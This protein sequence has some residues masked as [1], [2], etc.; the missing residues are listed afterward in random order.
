MRRI[1]LAL[2]F[3]APALA[4]D[5]PTGAT[6][7]SKPVVLQMANR[8]AP[9]LATDAD[10]FGRLVKA[11]AERDDAA[12]RGMKAGGGFVEVPTGTAA[13]TSAR[14]PAGRLLK[15]SGGPRD[16][17][18]G[19]A[20]E[21]FIREIKPLIREARTEPPRGARTAARVAAPAT[22]RAETSFRSSAREAPAGFYTASD[23][24]AS[25]AGPGHY[26]GAPTKKGGSCRRWVV[27]G[28]NCYQHGG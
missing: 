12:I 16:G 25:R 8:E 5:L 6:P 3:S 10:S 1:I 9:R 28:D 23:S 22:D 13:T 4:A 15:V 19:W 7:E 24:S 20:E 21:R 17:L 2:A 18:E 11:T 26:C 14:A 27:N